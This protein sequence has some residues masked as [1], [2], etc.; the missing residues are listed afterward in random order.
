MEGWRTTTSTLCPCDERNA[1][2]ANL[3]KQP[4]LWRYSSLWRMTHGNADA[5]ALLTLGR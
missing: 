2:R 5:Q 3:V 1:L 4:D